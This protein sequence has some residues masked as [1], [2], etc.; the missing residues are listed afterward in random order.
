MSNRNTSCQSTTKWCYRQ[1]I[2]S[3]RV[4]TRSEAGGTA[5]TF[6]NGLHTGLGSTAKPGYELGRVFL[7]VTGVLLWRYL[8]GEGTGNFR[9][10]T[11]IYSNMLL[12]RKLSNSNDEWT[13]RRRWK[14]YIKLRIWWRRFDYL[15]QVRTSSSRKTKILLRTGRSSQ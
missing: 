11:Y 8:W 6:G 10:L 9:D 3:P 14:L 7:P 15:R 2:S 1:S 13:F 12:T 4:Q 5:V